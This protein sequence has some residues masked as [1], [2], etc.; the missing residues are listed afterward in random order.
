MAN[1][2]MKKARTRVRRS[3]APNG[4]DSEGMGATD[5]PFLGVSA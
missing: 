4:R 1:K 5:P 2:E 3:V